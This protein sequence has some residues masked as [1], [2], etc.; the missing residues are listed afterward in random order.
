MGRHREPGRQVS[1]GLARGPRP[2]Q[3]TRPGTRHWR[4]PSANLL[5]SSAKRKCR[6]CLPSGIRCNLRE[7]RTDG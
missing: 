1:R 6:L 3:S 7:R 2:H 4:K 5:N